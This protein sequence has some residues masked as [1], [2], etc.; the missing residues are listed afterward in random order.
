M[1]ETATTT[2]TSS[3]HD[4]FLISVTEQLPTLDE[5]Y[6]FVAAE[7]SSGA[8]ATFCGITRD[9][10]RN[11]KVQKLSYEGYVPMAEKELKKLCLEGTIKFA[12]IQRI[13][14]VHILG[15]CPV[16]KASVIIACSSPHRKDSLHC[17]EFLIDELK[18]R[19][20]IWKLETY[21]GDDGCVWKENLEWHEGKQQ[22]TMTR[23]ENKSF[24][25]RNAK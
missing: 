6:Q 2:T 13:A 1:D 15:D 12:S 10:F 24:N 23:Q 4:K 22:R 25:D 17:C 11:K 5:C 20:P 8:V 16:G 9:N 21:E 18:A 19:I 3:T 14:V 7:S